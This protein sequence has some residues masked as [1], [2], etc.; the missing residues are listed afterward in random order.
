MPIISSTNSG[1]PSAAARIRSRAVPGRSAPPSR[2]S[3]SAPASSPASGS[4]RIEV[5]F[6]LPPPHPGRISSSSGRATQTSSS[7][8]SRVQS[9]RCSIRSRSIGSAQWMSS[10][11]TTS[12]RSFARC[13]K[14]L[15]TP[16]AASSGPAGSDQPNSPPTRRAIRSPSS[17]SARSS[18]S[19]AQRARGIVGL[20]DAGGLPH[21]LSERVVG[22]A[23]AVRE[24]SPPQDRGVRVGEELAHEPRLADP[25]RAEQREQVRGA[26]VARALEAAPEEL[27]LLRAPDHRR[28]EVPDVTG[29][30]DEHRGAAGTPAR[31]RTCPS[32]RAARPARPPRRP[33]R[34]GRSTHPAAP[35]PSRPPAR[36][37]RRRSRCHPSRAAGRRS[38]RPRRPR[39]YS[40]RSGS[41]CA[42]RG[43][44]PTRRSAR[45]APP[46]CRRR[47]APRATGRP[48]GAA[49]CRRRPSRH[50]RCT[51]RRC[52]RAARSR[53][54]SC[55]SSAPAPGG[56][57][58]GRGARRSRSSPPCRRRRS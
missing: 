27:E 35:H 22:D 9:A 6:I 23:L 17:A 16:H 5:A 48:R 19:F 41:R 39:R 57:P 47:L 20:R 44:A 1:L 13:S 30:V 11:T 56:A 42:R 54:P 7:S 43:R 26:L 24:A 33:S 15:R 14:S 29:R 40:R 55:R 49:G 34:G 37:G 36:A 28:V 58:R 51:S 25:G 38:G 18:V 3:S 31:A 46:A 10:N 21:D 2:L 8:A 52:R 50:R 12:G 45:R 53:R 32:A 4:S